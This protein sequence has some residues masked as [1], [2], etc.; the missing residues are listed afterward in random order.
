MR[1]IILAA[2]VASGSDTALKHQPRAM[3][4]VM[5][6][7][8]IQHVVEVLVEQGV[9]EF[10]FVLHENPEILREFLGEGD[11]WGSRFQFHLTK[12]PDQPWRALQHLPRK[13]TEE[14][15]V[16][17]RA[18]SLPALAPKELV[19]V[20][21]SPGPTLFCHETSVETWIGWGVLSHDILS[22]LLAEEDFEAKLFALAGEGGTCMP[23]AEVLQVSTWK[24]CL[25][26]NARLLERSFPGIAG[27]GKESDDGI[28]L[29]WNVRIH[30]S[31]RLIQPLYL[32]DRVKIEAGVTIGPNVVV[33]RDCLIGSGSSL[34][35]SLIFPRSYVGESLEIDGCVIDHKQLINVRLGSSVAVTDSFL[36]GD[37]TETTVRNALRKIGSQLFAGLLLLIFLPL[38]A[39]LC[40]YRRL[41]R[42]GPLLHFREVVRL[43][44]EEQENSWQMYKLKSF[45]SIDELASASSWG[46]FLLR[47][48]PGLINVMQGDL[49]LV[50]MPARSKAEV[51]VLDSDWRHLYLGKFAGL[52]REVDIYHGPKP[53]IDDHYVAE[54]YYAAK[55]CFS[56]DLLL[57]KGYLARLWS[58]SN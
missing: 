12:D 10:D 34:K 18:D 13:D 35:D 39:V 49:C 5:D 29:G 8:M 42:P 52:I 45:A 40:V 1:A 38:I 41:S 4:L 33:S 30:P 14:Q 17:V 32:G 21:Q 57:V 50:G 44:A 9:S 15:V 48:L 51:L 20:A 31:A 19:A 26:A 6:R 36:L 54:A 58:R 25:A 56:H 55:S 37:V 28:Y 3:R 47:F 11:R 46:D 23:V 24:N 16:I 53:S 22:G 7:P 27:T 2:F 43:P